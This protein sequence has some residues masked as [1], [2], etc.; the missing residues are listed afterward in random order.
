MSLLVR[1]VHDPATPGIPSLPQ[2]G[3]LV[4]GDPR[5]M[6]WATDLSREGATS[7]CVRSGVWEAT[8]GEHRSIKNESFEFCHLISGKVEL[9]EDGR[10]PQTFSAGD[11][12]IMKPGYRGIWRT[13]ETVRKLYVIVK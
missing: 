2:P 8:P 5:Y 1:I 12:F 4:S 10:P 13:L 11:S 6:T 7:G 9:I 3:Q